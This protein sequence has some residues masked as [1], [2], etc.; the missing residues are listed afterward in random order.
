V[1]CPSCRMSIPPTAHSMGCPNAN[2]S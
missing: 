1:E 2:S